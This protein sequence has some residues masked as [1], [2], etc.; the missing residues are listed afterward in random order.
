MMKIALI[1]ASGFVGKAVLKEASSRSHTVTALVR[2]PD[3]VEKLAG[4]T[5]KQVDVTDTKALAQAIIG[6]DV[7][8]SAFNGGWGDPDIYNKHLNGSKAIVDAAKAAKVR[9]IVV[10][11]AGSL[12]APDGSQFV[13]SPDFPAA[14]KDGALAARDSLKALRSETGL[15]WSFLSP[16][17]VLSPG[18]RTGKFRYGGDQPVFDANNESKISV[19]DLAVVLVDEAETAKHTGKRFTVGY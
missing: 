17:F 12:L 19:E 5:A 3:K 13:D 2:N 16:A 8:I 15:E 18:E 11:G 7:V 9:V 1:G 14:Y 10:G 4:V 6:Q